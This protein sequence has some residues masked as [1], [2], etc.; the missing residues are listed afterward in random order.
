MLPP[1]I[2]RYQQRFEVTWAD[3]APIEQVRFVVLDSETT[4]LNPRIDRIVTIGAVAV[5]A[6]EI[7]LEDSFA[8][9]GAFPRLPPRRRDRGPPHRSRCGHI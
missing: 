8:A 9:L 3:D 7:L 4:G 1:F 6:G 5:E 2:G